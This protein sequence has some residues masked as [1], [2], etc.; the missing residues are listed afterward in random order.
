MLSE[1]PY[2]FVAPSHSEVVGMVNLEAAIKN[3]S[4][5]YLSNWFR[6][7]TGQKWWYIN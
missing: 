1:M 5:Y 7:R 3:S 2:V 4:G 6:E